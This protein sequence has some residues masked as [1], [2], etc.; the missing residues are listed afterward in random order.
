MRYADLE[1]VGST[2][3]YLP[4]LAVRLIHGGINRQVFAKPSQ[5][6]CL[7]CDQ[8]MTRNWTGR[9]RLFSPPVAAA[10]P[11]PLEPCV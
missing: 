11:L 8:Q 5:G 3:D 10:L 6:S 4:M 2:S 9:A 7:A 1:P